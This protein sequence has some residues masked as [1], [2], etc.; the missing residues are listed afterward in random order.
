MGLSRVKSFR[1]E[2]GFNMTKPIDCCDVLILGSV[3]LSGPEEVFVGIA[4]SLGKR[5][6]RMPDGETGPRLEWIFWQKQIFERNSS[7]LSGA[8]DEAS[9]TDWRNQTVDE[10]LRLWSN[11]YH[12]RPE[13]HAD[14]LEF[15]KLGY[16]NEA[17][18]SYEI[19][20]RLKT[21]G[22][23]D[24]SCKF[25]VS[26][27][28]PYCVL[29]ACVAPESRLRTERA[30]E[31]RLI[32]EILEIADAIPADELAI[33]WDAAHEI[34]NLDGARPH[35][36]EDPEAGIVERLV[37][38]GEAVPRQVELGYHFCYGD[39]AHRHIVEPVDMGTM[40]RVANEVSKSINRPVQWLHMPVPKDRKDLSY[41]EPLRQLRLQLST[42]LYLGVVHY[43]DGFE[44]AMERIKVAHKI[45]RDFGIATECGFGRRAPDTV[46]LLLDIHKKVCD[47]MS[48][49][50]VSACT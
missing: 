28:T 23:I 1:G 30:Y 15:G 4:S 50:S 8:K 24:A 14:D 44:G 35:W 36:F 34:E 29:G 25:Q 2:Q 12:L 11:W 3:P 13:I 22:A 49:A 38:L 31:A 26:L 37:R 48:A 20:S 41:F 43:T 6:R 45:R 21:Q 32:S 40:V 9:S 39:F 18:K 42:R 27:P 7:F 19:F 33:Q 10:K 17:K 47:A 5:V 16:A 46:P